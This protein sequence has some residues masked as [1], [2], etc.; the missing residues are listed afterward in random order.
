MLT[1]PVAIHAQK[2]D[3]DLGIKLGA[4]FNNVNGS[5]WQNGYKANLLG[6]IFLGVTGKRLGGQIEGV[7]TQS[8]FVTGD[9]FN[10]IYQDAY[11]TGKDSVKGGSFKVNTLNIPLLLNIKLFSRA[12]IQI[13]PQFTG[14][15]SVR[16]K[17]ELFKDAKSLF[18]NSFDGVIGVDLKLPAHLDIGARYI[19]GLS[20]MH[21]TNSASSSQE[22]DDAWKQKTLQ[23]HIGYSIL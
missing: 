20:N 19:I 6:G 10:E 5:Y 15:V 23:I 2:M 7:F 3:V 22:V 4:S 16:D 13:G 9:K 12:V 14:V 21:K 1:L 18:N 17:D 8:T 11:Q